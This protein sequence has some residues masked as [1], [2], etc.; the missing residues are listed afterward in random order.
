MKYTNIIYEKK[1][2]V[3]KITL[4]RPQ[5]LNAM[6]SAMLEEISSALD[7]IESNEETCVLIITG[8]GRAFCTGMDLGEMLGSGSKNPGINSQQ[9]LHN[10]TSH[11]SI[12][13]RIRELSVPVICAVNGYS[14]KP[15]VT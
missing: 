2:G 1:D 8:G 11:P 12:C 15:R 14:I 4:N 7:D 9:I 5:V 6:N 13:R 10:P 3:A